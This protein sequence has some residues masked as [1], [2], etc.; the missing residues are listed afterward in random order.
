MLTKKDAIEIYEDT[1]NFDKYTQPVQDFIKEIIKSEDEDI[2]FVL[3]SHP[4]IIED[5]LPTKNPRYLEPNRFYNETEA[6]YIS[7]MGV[8][9]KR[10]IKLEDP[11]IH[12]VN[13]VLPGRRNNPVDK[14]AGIRPLAVYNPIHYQETPE[15][16]MDF[17]CSLTG[18]SP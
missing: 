14:K 18:K 2:Q 17:I 7:D 5:G 10:K 11:V 13:A 12:T 6:S 8:R 3:P 1:I 4:R 15:L 16:F 9:L